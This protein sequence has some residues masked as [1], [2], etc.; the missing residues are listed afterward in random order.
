MYEE[1]GVDIVSV[2]NN[3]IYDYGEISLLDTLDTLEQAEYLMLEP[4]EICRK[5]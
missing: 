5:P 3:H 4:E 1:M 2:A